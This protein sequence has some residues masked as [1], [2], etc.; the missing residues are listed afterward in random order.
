MKLLAFDTSSRACSVALLV[1]DEP[2]VTEQTVN[3]SY[4]HH[5]IL[6]LKQGQ[7][8]L[9]MIEE[10]LADSSL[11]IQDLTVIAY[12]CGPGSFTGIRIASCVA[13]GMGFAANL[14]IIPISSLTA[15]AQAA[16][17]EKQWERV[18][19]VVDARMGHVYWACYEVNPQGLVGLVG[20]EHA[21]TPEEIALPSDWI[22]EKA[23]WYGIGDGWVKYD[24]Q[25]RA[26]VQWPPLGLETELLPS[27]KA[28]LR[29]AKVHYEQGKYVSAQ[30]AQPVYLR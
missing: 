9:P 8:I 23:N 7:H 5:R 11:S 15:C 14:P 24:Q 20:G 17:D 2:L 10:V 6:P 22:T 21:S 18:V 1:S 29:L 4:S 27:A 25:L 26:N 12:G 19:V 3:K 16:Y 30:E 28:I 13:Q